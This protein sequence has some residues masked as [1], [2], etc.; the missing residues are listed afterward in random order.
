MAAR[1]R[2]ADLLGRVGGA[3][4]LAVFAD[5]APPEAAAIADRLREAVAGT[6]VAVG[7]GAGL[8]VSISGGLV[9]LDGGEAAP[10]AELLA[11]AD[12]AL[13]AAKAQGRNRIV[14]AGQ[15]LTAAAFTASET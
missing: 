6:A 3:E 7:G 10:F 12:A 11:R 1:C 9:A 5:V 13:Y 2:G 4:F 14:L 15:A 8:S